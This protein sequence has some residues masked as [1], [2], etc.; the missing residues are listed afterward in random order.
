MEVSHTTVERSMHADDG[1]MADRRIR[2]GLLLATVLLTFGT[3]FPVGVAQLW[4]SF[5]EGLWV[6]RDHTFFE[7]G[8]VQLVGE[9]RMIPDLMIIVAGVLPLAWFL[10]RTYPHLKKVEILDGESVWDRMGI[11]PTRID[12]K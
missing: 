10:F 1:A 6:A 11:D 7:R 8:F 2:H 3:L 4:T 9:W 5:T 12:K